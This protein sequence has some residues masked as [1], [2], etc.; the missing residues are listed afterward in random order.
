MPLKTKT[1]RKK[2]VPKYHLRHLH[3]ARIGLFSFLAFGLLGIQFIYNAQL[4]EARRPQVLAYATNVSVYG[5]YSAT[6]SARGANGLAALALNSKLNNSAQSKA[7]DMIAHDYWAHV[8]PTGVTPWYW[9][10]QAGYNYIK[11]GENLAYGFDNSQQI[12]DAWMGS[13]GHRANI[14]GDYKDVGF[15]IA[16][17]SN[18]QGGQYTV[19][20]AHYGKPYVAYVAPA[21]V[22][23][24]PKTTTKA[25]P[26]PAPAPAPTP[27]PKP[28]PKVAVTPKTTT[29]PAAKTPVEF[30]PDKPKEVTNFDFLLGGKASWAVYASLG[31]IGATSVGFAGTHWRLV[32]RGWRDSKHFILVHPALDSA[33]IIAGVFMFLTTASGYIH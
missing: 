15:G 26:K 4:A 13:S 7:N 9:F 11:A 20:V 10:K 22:K 30:A 1:R 32:R 19:V 2:T 24:T 25:A 5:L 17:G 12:N 29:N 23:T 3:M 14:L 28:T 18:Y 6:N 33:F 27:A 21:P 31:L 16:N 8:S